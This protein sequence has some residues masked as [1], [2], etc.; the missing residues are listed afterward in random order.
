MQLGWCLMNARTA[1][2]K[3]AVI[4]RYVRTGRAALHVEGDT[5]AIVL[6]DPD[7]AAV[8]RAFL[9]LCGVPRK[10]PRRQRAAVRRRTR[11]KGQTAQKF[12]GCR[13]RRTLR[14]DGW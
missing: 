5:E 4:R 1:S 14:V 3:N 10:R 12:A 2:L 8:F 9:R 13:C 6:F 11:P 7:D